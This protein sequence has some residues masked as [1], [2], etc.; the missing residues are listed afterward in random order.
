MRIKNQTLFRS[1][2]SIVVILQN[3]K[4]IDKVNRKISFLSE[5]GENC[6][7]TRRNYKGLVEAWENYY[8]SITSS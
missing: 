2:R 5:K 1:H 6:F 3:I 4:E 7:Y 8:A